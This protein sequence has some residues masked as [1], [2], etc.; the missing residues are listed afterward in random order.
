VENVGKVVV[1]AILIAAGLASVVRVG[2]GEALAPLS[3]FVEYGWGG[4]LAAMGATFITFQGFE[5]VAG[6]AGE[7][8][9]P[10]R[11]VPRGMFLSLGI[12]LVIYLPL[13]LVVASVG[14]P[15]GVDSVGE[16]AR[17]NPETLFAVA[18]SSYMGAFGFWLVVVAALLSTLT[19]LRANLLAGSR[20]AMAM[21]RHRTLPRGLERTD[22]APGRQWR[23]SSSS[24]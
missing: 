4:V 21:A 23:R 19:A 8:K 20:V 2:P 6:V 22:P 24:A 5:L 1:F 15:R 17:A 10:R 9:D 18:A 14:M 3:P 7:V 12:A 13:L 11:N 16:L